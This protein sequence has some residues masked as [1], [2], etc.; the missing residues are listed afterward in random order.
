MPVPFFCQR[1]AVTHEQAGMP[2]LLREFA[3][4]VHRLFIGAARYITNL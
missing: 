3:F 1:S 4:A 2:V